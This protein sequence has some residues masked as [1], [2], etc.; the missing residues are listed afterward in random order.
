[1][2]PVKDG[3]QRRVTQVAAEPASSRPQAQ[4]GP[5]VGQ[6][7]ATDRPRTGAT[8]KVSP[9]STACATWTASSDPVRTRSRPRARPSDERERAM[10]Y[11]S[12]WM[13]ANSTALTA[14]SRPAPAT[15]HAATGST[16]P[17]NERL[18]AERGDQRDGGEGEERVERSLRAAAPRAAAGRPRGSRAAGTRRRTAAR[19]GPGWPPRATLPPASAQRD[20]AAVERRSGRARAGSGT[21][22]ASSART[23][24]QRR[25]PAPRT[26]SAAAQAERKRDGTVTH[27]AWPRTPTTTAGQ[28][29]RDAGK[30]RALGSGPGRVHVPGIMARAPRPPR[31]RSTLLALPP[32]PACRAGP[33]REGWY[34]IVVLVD[35]SRG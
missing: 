26:T 3:R 20:R 30:R 11:G 6:A 21:R 33:L 2:G 35:A 7:L 19:A 14:R 25:A 24:G 28:R 29:Q 22:T 12:R 27:A 10:R 1:M 9:L 31:T 8:T 34:N 16:M 5:R 23:A 15:A 17:R 18:L 13:S 32:S 4:R